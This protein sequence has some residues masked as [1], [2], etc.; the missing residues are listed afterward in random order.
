MRVT[1]TSARL[2]LDRTVERNVEVIPRVVGSPAEGFELYNIELSPSTIAV[3]GPSSL[4]EG[5][6]QVTTEPVSVDGLRE[7]YSRMVRVELDPL[8]RVVRELNVA[9]ALDIGEERMRREIQGVPV[10]GLPED[11]KAT[12]TPDRLTVRIEGPRSLVEPLR[13]EDLLAQVPVSGLAPGRRYTLSLTASAGQSLCEPWNLSTFP[14]PDARPENLRVLFFKQLSLLGSTMGSRAE[15][16]TLLGLFRAGR[17]RPV[18]DRVLPLADVREAHRAM[19]AREQFGK[20][21]LVP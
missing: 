9:L 13:A 5:L 14:S 11:R 4:V 16:W 21:V 17:L 19:E 7:P 2:V 8:I 18:V 10:Q 12:I 20:I 1:P 15:L 3:A 6:E